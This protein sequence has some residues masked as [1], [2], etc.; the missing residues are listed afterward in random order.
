MVLRHS[1]RIIVGSSILILMVL[2]TAGIVWSQDAK[3]E[4]VPAYM[5]TYIGA[6]ADQVGS[7]KCLMCHPKRKPSN[8]FTH[9]AL[10]DLDTNSPYYGFGCEGCHGPGGKHNGNK[11]GIIN[12]NKLSPDEA[13][14]FCSK[15][16]SD[17]RSY[18]Y[19]SWLMSDHNAAGL[20]CLSC[21]GGHS[22]NDKFLKEKDQTEL[23]YSCHAEKRAEFSM[24]SHHPLKEGHITCDNCHNPHSGDNNNQLVAEGDELCFKCHG[25]KQGPFVFDHDL[26]PAM[27]GNGCLTCH[28]SHGGNADNLLRFP[29]RLCLQCHSDK[30]AEAHHPG[31][32]WATGC[33]SQIHGSYTSELFFD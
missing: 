9:L 24:R 28:F 25:D 18:N 33:H 31:T 19:K 22:E 30:T 11:L 21:H 5:D 4:V 27:G 15:C 32:C 29:H 12:P 3:K 20:D 13:N 26:S 7:A 1:T 2:L 17:L 6:D 14:Q 8:T 16:H 10:L 23:C